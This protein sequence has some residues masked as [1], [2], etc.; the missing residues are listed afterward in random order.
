MDSRSSAPETENFSL[1][2]EMLFHA[3]DKLF[4]EARRISAKY[5]EVGEVESPL[6]EPEQPESGSPE[7]TELN[8]TEKQ[9]DAESSTLS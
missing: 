5:E 4:Q 6:T 7:T 8:A 2:S 3:G 1:A 9:A